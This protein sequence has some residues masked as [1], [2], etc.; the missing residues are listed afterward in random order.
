MPKVPLREL[1]RTVGA[2]LKRLGYSDADAAI[3]QE[4]LLYGQERPP[5][6]TAGRPRRVLTRCGRAPT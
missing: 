4:V 6:R 5:L 2:A 3:T 1:E